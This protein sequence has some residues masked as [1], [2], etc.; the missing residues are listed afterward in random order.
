M[1][2]R[3]VT[4]AQR[5]RLQY[6]RLRGLKTAGA[7][8]RRLILLRR[9]EVR[10]V[11]SL[12]ED[13]GS[14]DEVV[15]IIQGQLSEEAYLPGWFEGLYVDCGTPRGRAAAAD[16]SRAKAAPDDD[17]WI[18]ALRRYAKNRAAENV[19]IVSGTL[20]RSLVRLVR[21]VMEE[22]A[23]LGIEKLTRYIYREYK[24]TLER[25]QCR[26]IAQTEAMIGMAEA[27][28]EAARSLDVG[29]LKQWCISGLGNTRDSHLVMDGVTVDMDEPFQLEGG[30][31][32]Y[33]HDT[34]MGA[35]ASEIINC[36]CDIYRI[37]K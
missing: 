16:L 5:R 37:P 35:D 14:A 26:R 2:V 6:L 36:A 17:V 11:L 7:Y 32:M 24:D 27:S 1:A 28:E 21:E 10:R 23:A 25:W 18:G 34:S 33:P 12:C 29:Y 31:L 8:E 4:S 19:T 20:K 15:T 3:K 13:A 30:L 9:S 22:E